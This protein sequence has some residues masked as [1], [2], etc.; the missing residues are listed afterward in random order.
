MRD[1]V[2]RRLAAGKIHRAQAEA[3]FLLDEVSELLNGRR[4]LRGWRLGNLSEDLLN[5]LKAEAVQV[6]GVAAEAARRLGYCFDIRRRRALEFGARLLA[7][8]QILALVPQAS[9]RCLLET[10]AR[11]EEQSGNFKAAV[12]AVELLVGTAPDDLVLVRN[13][14]RLVEAR[15]AAQAA[16]ERERILKSLL[17]ARVLPPSFPFP[18]DHDFYPHR[19]A[20]MKGVNISSL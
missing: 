8:P 14:L 18:A 9:A 16:A 1:G 7:E 5:K 17:G 20:A 4:D 11:I 2:E 19:C 13:L 10:H 6:S 15:G 3:A 12:T